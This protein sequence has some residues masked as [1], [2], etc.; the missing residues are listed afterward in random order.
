MFPE[1]PSGG[2]VVKSVVKTTPLRQQMM[3]DMVLHGLAVRTRETYVYV[4]VKLAKFYG[5]SPALMTS[6]DV[7][8]Y[9][10]DLVRVKKVPASTFGQHLAGIR[11]LFEKT[12]K[13][14]WDV[15]DLAR[16][17]SQKKLP[18]VLS[19]EEVL[20]ILSHITS[21]MIHMCLKLI[22]SCGLRISE[23]VN[24]MVG[25]VDGK[26]KCVMV[27][28]GKGKKD[29]RVP[30]PESVLEELRTHYRRVHFPRP[31]PAPSVKWLFPVRSMRVPYIARRFKKRFG[32]H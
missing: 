14:R 21:P 6:E 13:V 10:L 30:V 15:L 8:T 22:Y 1:F 12:L 7:R 25:H 29:R 27:R 24:M 11:F 26:Q 18:C 9:L 4:I 20:A 2:F 28:G 17:Q 19:I 5:K 23:G 32:P 3:E 16:P 31:G